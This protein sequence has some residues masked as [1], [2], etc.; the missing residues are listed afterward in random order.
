M[1]LTA[2]SDYSLRVLMYLGSADRHRLCT[3]AE[4]AQAYGISE[5]HLM[6][7]VNRLAQHGFVETIRGRSGG[8]RLGKT[9]IEIRL[10]D[11]LRAMEDDFDLVECFGTSDAC[12]ITSVCRLKHVVRRA[13]EA[14]F[15][16][17]DSWTLAD[18]IANRQSLRAELSQSQH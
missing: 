10:G 11:V 3:I 4:I 14:Y 18:V 5:N 6:K 15:A 7:V 9:A 2:M 1:R 8:V 17:F 13:L 12:R 16:E